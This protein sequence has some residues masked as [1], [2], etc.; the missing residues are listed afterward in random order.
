MILPLAALTFGCAAFQPGPREAEQ[1]ISVW[2]ENDLTIRADVTIRMVASTG[3][4]R[5]LGGVSPG[6]EVE[7]QY[8]ARSF[9]GTYALTATTASGDEIRSRF[10][11]LFSG[12]AVF[13]EL[14]RNELRVTRSGSGPK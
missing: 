14:Q 2:V 13:W 10:F 3:P 8:R 12:A 6:R 9:S 1:T 11:T 7:L 4:S 5:L